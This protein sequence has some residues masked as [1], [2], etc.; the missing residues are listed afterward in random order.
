MLAGQLLGRAEDDGDPGAHRPL[1]ARH[2]RVA[3]GRPS[4]GDG[5]HLAHREQP[6]LETQRLRVAGVSGRRPI[7]ARLAVVVAEQRVRELE[8]AARGA[9][10]A[11]LDLLEAR[12]GHELPRPLDHDGPV[13]RRRRIEQQGHGEHAEARRGRVDGERPR[14]MAPV[15]RDFHGEIRATAATGHVIHP[16]PIAHAKGAG[17][18][19]DER[20]S[21]RPHDAARDDGAAAGRDLS[22]SGPS[23]HRRA[24]RVALAEAARQVPEAQ[25]AQRQ[26]QGRG[27]GEPRPQLHRNGG[28]HHAVVPGGEERPERQEGEAADAE[29][30]ALHSSTLRNL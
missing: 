20:R 18:R 17:E 23:Q 27:E 29:P 26:E 1:A 9:K 3:V 30:G 7:A 21:E 11:H 2:D 16:V 8:R 4:S 25:Q 15:D 19:C 22:R 24:P 12:R 28:R 13:P 5:G 10:Q 6:L 14:G